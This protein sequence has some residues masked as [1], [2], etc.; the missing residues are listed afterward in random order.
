MEEP[1]TAPPAPASSET[2]RIH[3]TDDWA[4]IESAQFSISMRSEWGDVENVPVQFTNQFS[5]SVGLTSHRGTPDAIYLT[6]G[7][8][9]LPIMLGSPDDV[10]ERLEAKGKLTVSILARFSLTRDRLDELIEVL[11]S[12]RRQHDAVVGKLVGKEQP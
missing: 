12:V 9:S 2:P 10:R 1:S 6:F 4:E 7:H 5:A 11:D 3:V 8:V